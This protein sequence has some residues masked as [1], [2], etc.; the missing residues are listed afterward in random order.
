M[1]SAV[2][3]DVFISYS[4]EDKAVAD[5][6][7]ARLEARGVRCWIAP[8]DVVPG[9]PYGESISNA[10]Q[11]TQFLVLVLSGNANRSPHVPREVEK[12][13]SFGKTI[14]PFR[15]EDV[16]PSTTL[17]Y[18]ITSIHWLDALTPPLV[19]HIEK[20]ADTVERYLPGDAASKSAGPAIPPKSAASSESFHRTTPRWAIAAAAMAALVIAVPAMIWLWPNEADQVAMR[21]EN[22]VARQSTESPPPRSSPSGTTPSELATA[23]PSVAKEED[24]LGGPGTESAAKS[25]DPQSAAAGQSSAKELGHDLVPQAVWDAAKRVAPGIEFALSSRRRE[26]D[27]FYYTIEGTTADGQSVF[28]ECDA[29]GKYPLVYWELPEDEISQP[30]RQVLKSNLAGVKVERICGAGYMLG[31]LLKYR[32]EGVRNGNRLDV[33]I[34]PDA[35]LAMNTYG[36]EKVYINEVPLDAVA[37]EDMK[38]AAKAQPDVTWHMAEIKMVTGSKVLTLYGKNSQGHEVELIRVEGYGP[39]FYITVPPQHIAEALR[40]AIG[41]SHPDFAL[42]TI[43][44][45]GKETPEIVDYYFKGYIGDQYAE[46]LSD[47]DGKQVTRIQ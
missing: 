15:I 39:H 47:P 17:G 32:L 46:F 13:A 42:K 21:E 24:P 5:A 1:G 45:H 34:A 3:H 40:A 11:E 22:A 8:R 7:C 37:A 25:T 12:A 29:K 27:D 2:A 26:P 44:A 33:L 36:G 10:L 43:Q 18:F 20:L 9:K 6:V 38:M 31:D 30:V 16:T 4:S 19:Q 28:V 41:S 35:S 14:I 23:A